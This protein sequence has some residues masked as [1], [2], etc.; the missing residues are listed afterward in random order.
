MTE[1]SDD[2]EPAWLELANESTIEFE[3]D[4]TASGYPDGYVSDGTI[5]G[6][7]VVESGMTYYDDALMRCRH[8]GLMHRDIIGT[9]EDDAEPV[10]GFPY[11]CPACDE[12]TPHDRLRA[13][14]A[15]PVKWRLSCPECG[16]ET[17]TWTDPNEGDEGMQMPECPQCLPEPDTPEEDIASLRDI[18]GVGKW[19][20]S[21]LYNAGYQSKD[22][23]RAASQSDLSSLT[24]IGNALAA[25]IKADVGGIDEVGDAI[26]DHDS[27]GEPTPPGPDFSSDP[28]LAIEWVWWDI[29]TAPDVKES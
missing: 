3:A 11:Q 8:C 15:T 24:G 29:E 20:A 4:E 27:I 22:Q 17:M 6:V 10:E 26:T 28:T 14:S 9:P 12:D 18:S 1:G 2:D 23:I 13:V 7:P 19:K 25:R 16:Y 21:T 5:A